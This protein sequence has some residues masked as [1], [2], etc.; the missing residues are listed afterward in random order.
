M[1][2]GGSPEGPERSGGRRCRRAPGGQRLVGGC[3][4][5]AGRKRTSFHRKLTPL[6]PGPPLTHRVGADCKVR[7]VRAGGPRPLMPS[8][9]SARRP[10]YLYWLFSL[11]RR[12]HVAR[13]TPAD[14]H[15]A[16]SCSSGVPARRFS[17]ERR[18][19]MAVAPRCRYQ[20]RRSRWPSPVGRESAS[21]LAAA[22]RV[23]AG[24]GRSRRRPR[25][26]A[27]IE[28]PAKTWVP[29]SMSG[30]EAGHPRRRDKENTDAK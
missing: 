27:H 3:R 15:G 5:E 24:R 6:P 29:P 16:R 2:P 10:I 9:A 21:Q 18:E 4:V 23:A 22:D 17:P 19:Q 26:G 20:V 25:A 14:S 13:L 30:L 28:V 11:T 8:R 1:R 12:Y 7:E